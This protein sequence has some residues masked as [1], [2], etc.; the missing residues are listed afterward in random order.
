MGWTSGFL[1][2]TET[3]NAKRLEQNHGAVQV[4]Q[5]ALGKSSTAKP[6]TKPL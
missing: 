6:G 1:E 4:N 2:I 5:S 3:L